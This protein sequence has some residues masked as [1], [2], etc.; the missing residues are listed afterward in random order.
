MRVAI[1]GASGMI[2]PVL[3]R[4]LAANGHSV[5]G[6][7]RAP[8]PGWIQ[9]DPARGALDPR[10]LAGV[11][12]IVHL[13]GKNLAEG[14]WSAAAKREIWSSRV[15]AGHLLAAAAARMDVPPRAYVT[16]SGVSYYGDRGDE[17]LDES[18]SRGS[19][20]LAELCEAWEA[21]AQ[22]AAACGAR[23]VA[24][25]TGVTLESL[26]RRL[27]LPFALGL[28]TRVGNGRQWISWI[29]LEDIARLYAHVL[30]THTIRGV[31]NGVAPEP[32]TNAT[33]TRA[34]AAALGRPALFVAP[35]FALRLMLGGEMAD[36]TLLAS[37]RVAPAVALAHGFAFTAPSLDV[38]LP[39]ALGKRAA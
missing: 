17:L 27:R 14:R 1:S 11:D 15:D 16:A 7:S 36:S 29:L 20:F 22:P 28:G 6:I 39:L 5:V 13:A 18:S 37:G 8:R 26:T 24:M 25:R 31:V 32:A 2:G 21:A 9:W 4:L 38:A 34:L 19:G 35:P 12:A 10:A 3:A 33:F 23:V 30:V